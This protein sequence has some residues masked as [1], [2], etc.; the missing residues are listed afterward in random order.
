MFSELGKVPRVMRRMTAM[1]PIETVPQATVDGN[2]LRLIASGKD[3]LA[4][5]LEL[6]DGAQEPLTVHRVMLMRQGLETGMRT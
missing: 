3:R 1:T 4:A 5:I 6:I 2:R